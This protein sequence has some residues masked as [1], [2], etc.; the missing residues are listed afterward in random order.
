MLVINT[1]EF[2]IVWL[3]G[4]VLGVKEFEMALGLRRQGWRRDENGSRASA[5][6]ATR[7]RLY[8][9]IWCH[10]PLNSSSGRDH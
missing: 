10:R 7:A 2:D 3:A 5:L 9:A 1:I 6:S 4:L 8:A